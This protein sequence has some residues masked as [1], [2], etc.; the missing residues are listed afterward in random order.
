MK[1]PIHEGWSLTGVLA[2]YSPL[3][4]SYENWM[5]HVY[6]DTIP[7]TV[8]GGVHY[9]LFRAGII[10]NPYVDMNS[11]SCEWTENRWWLYKTQVILEK[12]QA[13]KKYLVF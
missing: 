3:I 4:P 8:P 9:D 2:G 13:K 12:K 5:H 1:Q 10:E 7:A 6:T 11:L